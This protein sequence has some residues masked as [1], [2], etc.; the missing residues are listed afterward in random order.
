MPPHHLTNFEIQE[1]YQNKAK[2]NRIYS[3]N[4][5]PKKKIRHM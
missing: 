4:N 5:L 2:F 1:Y 3:T